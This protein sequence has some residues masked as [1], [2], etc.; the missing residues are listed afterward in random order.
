MPKFSNYYVV[1]FRY[2]VEVHDADGVGQAVSK[3]IRM[4]ERVWGF[5]PD[6]WHARIFEYT[7]GEAIPGLSREFFYNP[8]SHSYREIVKNIG[9]HQDM[10]NKGLTPDDVYDYDKIISK[11]SLDEEDVP[12]ELENESD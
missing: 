11:A 7:T 2:P 4:C 3:G 1:E 9:Y 12:I 8:N 6:S 10:V 5:R